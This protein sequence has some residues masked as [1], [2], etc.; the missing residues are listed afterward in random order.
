VQ[1]RRREST[2]CRIPFENALI[3]LPRASQLQQLDESDDL[4]SELVLADPRSRPTSVST[5]R[6]SDACR[7]M[8]PRA[9]S[10]CA[11]ALHRSRRQGTPVQRG[12]PELGSR[13]P[14]TRLTVVLL[15]EPFGPR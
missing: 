2:R 14:T 8:A 7:G 13:S 12:V 15:P 10:R 6:R 5:R 4:P 1:Q 3:V 9:R 11:A